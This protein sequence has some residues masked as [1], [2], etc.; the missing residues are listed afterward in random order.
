MAWWLFLFL[1]IVLC[2][3]GLSWFCIVYGFSVSEQKGRDMEEYFVAELKLT[4]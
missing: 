1:I 4:D 3:V 2:I